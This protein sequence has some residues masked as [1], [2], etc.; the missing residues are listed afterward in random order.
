MKLLLDTHALLWWLVDEPRLPERVT[1]MIADRRNEVLVSAVSCYE[2]AYKAWRG[3]LPV[4]LSAI[5]AAV[6]DCGFLLVAISCD[7]AAHA[8]SL[9]WAHRDPWDRLLAAQTQ[10]EQ[11]ELLSADPVF[12][13]LGLARRW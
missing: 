4:D 11:C 12:D 7:H 2:I 6:R 10:I 5:A 8:G 3:K 13:S 1:V 9:R